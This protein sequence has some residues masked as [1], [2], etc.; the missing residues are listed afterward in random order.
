MH[1]SKLALALASGVLLVGVAAPA[2]AEGGAT[3]RRVIESTPAASGERGTTELRATN[4]GVELVWVSPEPLPYVDA[5]PQF[6]LDG[7]VLGTPTVGP[8]QR[9]LSL[10]VDA[11]RPIDL[12]QVEVWLGPRRLDRAGMPVEAATTGPAETDQVAEALDVDPSAEGGFATRTIDYEADPLPWP[13]F[14]RPMETVGHAVLPV[15]ATDAPLVLFLHGRHQPCYFSGAADASDTACPGPLT[16]IPSQLGYDYLQQ[17]L[18]SQG[19]ATVSIA[20]NVINGDDWQSP[21]GGAAARAASIRYHLGLLADWDGTPSNVDWF[22]ALD[23]DQ[24]VLIGHSRGGEGVDAAVIESE[25]TDPFTVVGQVLI[26]PVDFSWQTAGYTPTSLFLPSCDGDVFDLQGQRYIDAT[27]TAAPDDPSLRSSILM[28]GANHNFFNTEW[29]PGIS[30]APSF[31]DWFGPG[32]R[33]CGNSSPRRLSA[34]EQRKVAKVYVAASVDAF[35]HGTQSS[36]NVLD[37]GGP[38]IPPGVPDARVRTHALGG[39]RTTLRAGV[40]ATLVHRAEPC[41]SVTGGPAQVDGVTLDPCG[42]GQFPREMHWSPTQSFFGSPAATTVAELGATEQYSFEWTAPNQVG[43]ITPD[44]A[45]DAS[46]PGASID[47]R[48][49]ADPNFAAPRV[50][51]RLGDGSST[52]TSSPVSLQAFP[53][54]AAWAQPVRVDL[55]GATIDTSAITSVELVGRSGSGRVIVLDTSVRRVGLTPVP[56]RQLPTLHLGD[57]TVDEGDGPGAGTAL[58]PF[59]LTGDLSQPSSFGVSIDQSSFD[60]FPP[61]LVRRVEVDAGVAGG[62]IEVPYEADT[63]DELPFKAQFVL[64]SPLTG[65]QAAD[66][67]GKARIADDDAA[68]TIHLSALRSPVDSGGRIGYRMRLSAPRDD[69]T[70]GTIQAVVQQGVP[71]IR[72]TDV[73]DSWKR[74]RLPQP[75][76]RRPLSTALAHSGEFF[77]VDQGSL[78]ADL[79]IPTIDRPLG[80]TRSMTITVNGSNPATIRL[81]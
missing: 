57:V 21:D 66:D 19:I 47:L 27:Q 64:A 67:L 36:V 52:W 26:A 2:H 56:D 58:V 41:A 12:A 49:V 15:G 5:A 48:V 75:N 53:G 81:R 10:L 37:R 11:E 1:R 35:L 20:A 70:I 22:G 14:D 79:G 74:F 25:P 30:Q 78:T 73:P 77:F 51:V 63:L 29:T 34:A 6:R 46:G 43:G 61:P 33:N 50:A 55:D 9:T 39:H 80:V 8:D 24:V 31:D 71:Q 28:T 59:T 45:L 4:R 65:M 44:A 62:T 17:M 16:P 23:M 76:R 60:A 38:V 68:P 40:D 18:A 32:D 3:G 72:T 7:E 13:E 42:F 54:Q 69:F